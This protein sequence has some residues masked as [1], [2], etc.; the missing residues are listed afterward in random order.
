M[1][2][3]IDA[4][5]CDCPALDDGVFPVGTGSAEQDTLL[6]TPYWGRVRTRAEIF[7]TELALTQ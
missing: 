7:Q 3:V 4:T 2:T 5:A 1:H 6:R